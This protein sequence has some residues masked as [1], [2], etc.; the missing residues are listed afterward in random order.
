[1]S[2]YN[3]LQWNCRGYRSQY[4]DLKRLLFLKH[5]AVCLLQETMLGDLTPRPPS[6]YL[7]HTDFN[8]PTPGN[9]LATLIRNDIPH[10]KLNIRTNLQATAFKISLDKQYTICNLYIKPHDRIT[11]QEITNIITQ[12]PPPAIIC[13]DFNSRHQLWDLHCTRPDAR[14]QII[15]SV[16]TNTRM[17]ILNTGKPTHFHLQNNSQSAIDLTLSSADIVTDIIWDTLEDVYGSD[18]YPINLNI[19]QCENPTSQIRYL[20]YKANWRNFEDNTYISEDEINNTEALEDLVNCYYRIIVS[21][22]DSSIPKSSGLLRPKKVPWWTEECTQANR[23]R[24]AALRKY[25]NSRLV[26]DKIAFCRAR[27]IARNVQIN[28]K[29]TSWQKYIQS[30]NSDTPM[31]KIWRRIKKIKGNYQPIKPICLIKNGNYITKESEVAELMACHYEKISSN[32]SYSPQFQRLLQRKEHTIDFST[33]REYSYNSNI[34]E[35]ELKRMLMC[36]KKSAPGEDN[37]TYNM[38]SKAHPNSRK[39]LLKIMNKAFDLGV[40]PEQWLKSITLSFTKPNKPQNEEESQR[41]ISLTSCPG[42]VLEKILNTRLTYYLES[43][44]YIPNNQ[45]GFRRMHSTIDALNKFTTDITTALNNKQQVLC[46]SFDMKKAYDT[47]WRHGI[48]RALYETGLR[49]KLPIYISKFLSNRSFRTKI[50]NTI[51][52]PHRL[53]QGVPQGSVLSCTLFSLAINGILKIIPNNI[54]A[55]LYVDDL[56]IY[57]SG[58]HIPGMERRLQNAINKISSFADTHGFTFSAPKT[59]CIHFHRKKHF[60]SP[61]KLTLNGRIIPNRDN[62]TYLG[63]T[64]DQKLNW[65]EHIKRVKIETIKRLDLLKC[66]SHTKWGSDR[67]TMLRLYNA[68]IRSKLEYGSFLIN[69]A[70]EKTLKQ[71]DTVQNAALRL[72]TGAYRSSPIESI[73]AECG[74]PPLKKRRA[75]L[76]LQYYARSL[77]LE[78]SAAYPYIQLDDEP[79]E[80]NNNTT[81]DKI[82]Q[83]LNTTNLSISTIPYCF[84]EIPVWQLSSDLLCT[85][86]KYPKKGT[87]SDLQMRCLFNEH[88]RQYHHNQFTI[89]SDGAKAENGASCAAV[90]FNDSRRKKLMT[91]TSIFSAELYGLICALQIAKKTQNTRITIF[92]DSQSAIKVIEHYDTNHPIIAKIITK[93]LDLQQKGKKI[94]VCWCPSHIGIAGNERADREATSALQS[95]LPV[96][97]NVLP[98]RDWYPIIKK[99]I[100]RTWNAEW[101]MI[102]GNKLRQIKPTVYPWTSS[103]QPTRKNSII[104]TRIRIGHTKLTHQHLMENRPPPYCEDCLVPLSIHHVLAECPSNVEARLR[105]YPQTC[106]LS[107]TE[108]LKKMISEENDTR[109]NSENL[110][111]YLTDIDVFNSII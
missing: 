33:N 54:E 74:I 71:L 1:M 34:T 100:K 75:Q 106:G 61:L 14:G 7:L 79:H 81:R 9:G 47:T 40:V 15:E 92:C 52:E 35:I 63:M 69:T 56:L 24:K 10:I 82:R 58:T 98:C 44:K 3:I 51:S 68:V 95:N 72:C 49:G 8:N 53:E 55:S 76:L 93:L 27:A 88:Y 37:I 12:L 39:L 78:T 6:G 19:S 104:L 86:Y 57:C 60:Q 94:T 77:Q 42:K 85:S 64:F 65:T 25:Q 84:P 89:Y 16:L 80:G 103:N 59:N 66:I 70:Q 45:Y 110:F 13:G 23:D 46:I 28:A 5:P 96:S 101:Q 29:K 107:S 90:S 108:T 111:K 99:E 50:G 62:I 91:E 21:A 20:E 41:P 48:L 83:E 36:S 17:A 11:N 102:Q 87:C 73:Y 67:T 30:L 22:A 43:N 4:T 32:R 97:N 2:G 105:H 18:H 38:I 26:V 31:S 109:F